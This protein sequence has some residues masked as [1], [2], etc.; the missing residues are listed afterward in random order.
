[1]SLWGHALLVGAGAHRYQDGLRAH[2]QDVVATTSL[3]EALRVLEQD[4]P[5][6]FAL[7]DVDSLIGSML[8]ALLGGHNKAPPIVFAIHARPLTTNDAF[9]FARCGVGELLPANANDSDLLAALHRARMESLPSFRAFLSAYVG[10][11]GLF[12]LEAEI[13]AVAVTEALA[14]VGGNRTQAARLLGVPRPIVQ[15]SLKPKAPRKASTARA[16][17]S[18][19]APVPAAHSSSTLATNETAPPT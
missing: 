17:G 16:R 11:M 9:A 6:A 3:P 8:V 2:F 19:A 15:R 5:T 14:R 12:E 7:I 10:R 4:A 13:R 18:R 1:M